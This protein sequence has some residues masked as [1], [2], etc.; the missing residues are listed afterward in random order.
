MTIPFRHYAA[1]PKCGNQHPLEDEFSQW[2]R[3]HKLLQSQDGY[4]IMDKDMVIHRCR[5]DGN[6][7]KQYVMFVEVKTNN[8][9]PSKSQRDTM[10]IIDQLFRDRRSTPTKKNDRLQTDGVN[11]EV[12]S[13]YCG[14]RVKVQAL[15]NHLLVMSGTSPENSQDIWWDKKSITKEILLK[16][17]QIE[18]DPDTFTALSARSHHAEK[19]LFKL[20]DS[21]SGV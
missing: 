18:I 16:L 6:R 20:F 1:C 13:I 2:V 10:F 21:A 9:T 4:V 3:G 7:M 8:A 19:P 5:I 12:Y 15:G 14:Q 11:H 17:L